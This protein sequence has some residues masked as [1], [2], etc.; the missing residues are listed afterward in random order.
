VDIELNILEQ[1][2]TSTDDCQPTARV[3]VGPATFRTCD[4][5]YNALGLPAQ[6]GPVRGLKVIVPLN[7]TPMAMHPMFDPT[8]AQLQV[9]VRSASA[10]GE[11]AGRAW[12]IVESIRAL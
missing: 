4:Q 8:G 3:R 11:G 2:V 9:I 7:Q 10:N 6:T 1:G 5:T 12:R